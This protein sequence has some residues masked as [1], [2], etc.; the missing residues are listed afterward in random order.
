MK[1]RTLLYTLPA[2]AAMFLAATLTPAHADVQDRLYDFTDAYYLQN[3][4]NPSA[5]VGRRQ[6]VAPLATTDRPIFPYQRNVRALLTL[7]AYDHSGNPW[8]FTVLG[9]LSASGFTSN[10]AGQ[11]ARQIAETSIEY[12]FPRRG[13]NPMGLGATRQSVLL[14]MRNGYFS[15][16]PLGLWVHVWVSYTDRAFN[17]PEGRAELADLARRN[18]LDLDG[19]PRI[20]TVGD[21]DRLF[22]KGLITKLKAPL[23]DGTRYAICPVIKDPTDGGIAPDQFLAF[24]RKADGTPLEPFFVRHFESLRTTGRWAG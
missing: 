4:V 16:N 18:G 2:L 11:R 21:I 20:R 13:T 9:G 3:G 10:A 1:R 7:P 12:V 5:I 6:A 8:F 24:T 22:S 15:N 23:D 19:T 17:T 14:D